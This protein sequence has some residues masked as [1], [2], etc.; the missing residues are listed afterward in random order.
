[1]EQ[2]FSGFISLQN[3]SGQQPGDTIRIQASSVPVCDTLPAAAAAAEGRPYCS[4][5]PEYNM[6]H[7]YLCYLP[8][9]AADLLPQ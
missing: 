5:A 3:I 1:M 2:V 8:T 9:L 7:E 6:Q 4:K